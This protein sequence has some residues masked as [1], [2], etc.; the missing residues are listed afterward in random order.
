MYNRSLIVMAIFVIA[1]G[2]VLIWY[3]AQQFFDQYWGITS[4]AQRRAQAAMAA[5]A[6]PPAVPEAPAAEAPAAAGEA[7]AAA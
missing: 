1:I 3:R 4:L 7:P 5:A 2:V 6:A